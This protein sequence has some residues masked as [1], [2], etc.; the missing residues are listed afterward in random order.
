M[1]EN[2]A[3]GSTRQSDNGIRRVKIADLLPDRRNANLHSERGT[4][5]VSRS[6]EKLGAGRSILIDRDNEI[7]AGN[8]TAEQAASMG[9]EEVIIVPTDG[10][11]LVAVQ[12]MDMDLD[13]PTT[14]AREMA[15]ADNRAAVVSIDFDPVIIA[16]DVGAGMDLGDWWQDFELEEMG[17][18]GASNGAA[19][20]S[21]VDYD[22][23]HLI[24]IEC[25]SE[26]HQAQLLERFISEGIECRALVS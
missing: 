15:Y 14:A 3:G 16:E 19:D 5:M 25:S 22:S 6:L 9:L 24:L 18:I 1:T 13:D 7:I 11:T 10:K 12:R 2:Q 26:Q 20:S 23:E 17:V 21:E 8:L 4:Y